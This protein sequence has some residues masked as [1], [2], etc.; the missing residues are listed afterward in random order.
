MQRPEVILADEP[1]GNLDPI[2]TW[3]IISLLQKINELGTTVLLATHDREII[4]AIG[5]RVVVLEKGEVISDKED[6]KY[7]M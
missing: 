2:H 3:E 6:G 5:K 7:L 1:T 4:N